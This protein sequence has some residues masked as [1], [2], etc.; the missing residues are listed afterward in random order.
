MYTHKSYEEH[1]QDTADPSDRRTIRRRHLI[2][3]LRVWNQENG[4]LIG[5]IVDITTEGLMLI[6]EQK[7]PRGQV[8][9][10]EINWQ[11]ADQKEQTIS[12]RAESLWSDND[13]NPLFHDTGF[14]LLDD[15]NDV[16]API[17]EL[18]EQYGFRE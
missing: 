1:Q 12:F 13:I 9:Q 11:D 4:E 10:M 7:I 6:S 5:H 18:I 3:Y 14:S 8:Y 15:S 2:Y 16:L 17:R